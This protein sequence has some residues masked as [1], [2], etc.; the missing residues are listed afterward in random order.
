MKGKWLKK[1]EELYREARKNGW[2]L[3]TKSHD[4]ILMPENWE[5]KK[6]DGD[7][8]FKD[9]YNGAGFALAPGGEKIMKLW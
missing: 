3:I 8:E 5:R 9:A 4:G 6:P 7:W 1:G 2:E